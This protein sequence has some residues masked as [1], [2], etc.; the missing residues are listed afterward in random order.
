MEIPTP[1]CGLVRNDNVVRGHGFPLQIPIFRL[2]HKADSPRKDLSEDN[3]N[4]F[5]NYHNCPLSIVN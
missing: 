2:L 4:Y 3:R 1:V 5:K